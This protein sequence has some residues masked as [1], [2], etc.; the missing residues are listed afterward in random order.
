[1][2]Q[3]SSA[4]SEHPDAL[5]F[6]R[7]GDFYELFHEDAKEASERLD[8]TS[9]KLVTVAISDPLATAEQLQTFLGLDLDVEKMAAS[10]DP[11]LYRN[12]DAESS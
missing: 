12:R 7:M 6:F 4:K 5:L 11:K 3:Y 1:M 8:I 2:R 10:V 9:A